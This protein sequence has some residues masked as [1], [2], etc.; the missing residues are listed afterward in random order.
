MF[1]DPRPLDERALYKLLIGSVVPRPIAWTSTVSASGRR[2]LA[3]FSFFTVVSR[4]P[5][6]VSLT[7]ETHDDGRQKD[8]FRNITETHDFVVNVVSA[9]N[10]ERMHLSSGEYPPDVD[11][12][13]VAGVPAVPSELV[14]SPR[15][16]DAL[17]AL[18]CRLHD[19]LTP[20][21]DTVV[22]GEL[23]GCHV[24][25]SL[26]CE[27]RIDQARLDPLARVAASFAPLGDV[28]SLRQ[29]PTCP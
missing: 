27:G 10:A 25:E 15:V 8:T 16:G 3:P 11:E 20:G 17:V 22:V 4:K 26:W 2:N 12:F 19:V 13:A 5:P 14:R 23:V 9:S 21:G 29:E 1:I 28:F 6:L 18:E 24:H 7:I